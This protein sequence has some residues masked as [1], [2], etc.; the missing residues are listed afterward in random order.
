MLIEAN[1]EMS[2]HNVLWIC[3]VF[4]TGRVSTRSGGVVKW[5]IY[6]T[7]IHTIIHLHIRTTYKS[8]ILN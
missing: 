6:C 3:P 7:T 4:G 1:V 2:E 8:S 5:G